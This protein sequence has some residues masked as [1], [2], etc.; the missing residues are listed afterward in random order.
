MSS[1]PSLAACLLCLLLLDA[2]AGGPEDWPCWRG[3]QATNVSLERGWSS[4]G[5][6]RPLWQARVGSGYSSPVVCAGR[7]VIAGYFEDESTPHAGSD[8]VSCLDAESGEELWSSTYPAQAFDNEH[9]GGALSSATIVG[10]VVFVPTRSGEVRAFSLA[11]GAL[12]WQVDLKQR[13]GVDPGRYGFASS[14][15][16]VGSTIVLNAERTLALERVSGE[17]SW[18]S[19]NYEARYSTPAAI[20]LGERECLVLFGSAGLVALDAN[21]GELVRKHVFTEK[22][23]NVEGATPI[24]VGQRVFI[25][26]AYDH[27]GQLVDFGPELPELV[28]GTKTMRSKMAGCTLWEGHLYGFDE[29]MLRCIALADGAE[30]WRQR[31]LGQ[32]ALS[33]ADGRLLTTSSK[34]ELIV[35]RATPQAFV[36]ESRRQ[37][38]EGG[39]FWTAPVLASGRIYFRGS[40][41]ELV[42]LDHRS[43]V[44]ARELAAQSAGTGS[45]AT[46]LPSPAALLERYLRVAGYDRQPMTG[47]RMQGRLH[48]EALGLEDSAASW[49]ITPEG[50][51]HVRYDLP[52]SMPGA[53][54]IY[55][56]GEHAWEV[57]PRRGGG[58]IEGSELDELRRTRG[59]RDLFE[60]VPAGLAAQTVGL[61]DFHGLECL[62]VDVQLT[63]DVTRSVFFDP[64]T[65][66]LAGRTSEQE[67]TV[68][69]GEW[70]E[71]GGVWLP[72]ERTDFRLDDGEESRWRFREASFET[73]PEESFAMP[74]DVRDQLP[75][76]EGFKPLFN[77]RDLAGWLPVNTAPS[78][79]QVID[80]MLHCSGKPTGELRTQR[81]YQNFVLEFEWR[82]L[83]PGGNAGLFVWADDLTARGVPFHRGIEVQVLDT[84]YGEGEGHTT[85]GDIFPIH[86]ARMTP[87]NG[88]GGSRAFPSELRSKPS[89]EWNHYR[90]TCQDG[91]ITLAVNGAL[92][93]R[94]REAWPSKGYLC[95]E[96]EGG[97]VDYRGL[98][99]RELPETPLDASRVARVDRGYDS[100]YSGLDLVGW[101]ASEAGLASWQPR[102]WI[103]ACTGAATGAEARLSSVESYSDFGF[104]LDL[105]I[106]EDVP[107]ARLLLRGE[108]PLSLDPRAHG[109]A[110][111]AGW[112][113]F[114]G[115]LIGDVLELRIDDQR[116]LEETLDELPEAGSLCIEP[117]GPCEF[118]NLFV[119]TDA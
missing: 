96:S 9:A 64:R 43:T 11:D 29:S 47:L 90:V 104:L 76:A 81:M 16:V 88:R 58:P 94:G 78:T 7:L 82:H 26:S 95:L 77:G 102:D 2:R 56:D 67:S 38:V 48:I 21:S 112:H 13:H 68:V 74:Q 22:A 30:C 28:W 71:F 63:P 46:E 23:R 98:R 119:T 65:G 60:P 113:R 40:L 15:L 36:E 83:V 34:G 18:I 20:T 42:C 85:H 66:L 109:Q 44:P 8:R 41:G 99:I 106:D 49:E 79:W 37:V 53:I 116:V 114:E 86:G 97:E 70:R 107:P 72:F 105:R 31:G 87:V 33:I 32:G 39:V 91:E 80:G 24:V 69:L 62:R 115:S 111:R 45:T 14:A 5:R 27:G 101:S 55:F 100:L 84:A 103:L 57:N 1:T 75:D 52:P 93:T 35:A 54:D 59:L 50:R 12:L 4:T 25:S 108:L 118:A 73:S 3:P 117:G 51:W 61:E 110:F 92:V 89:P 19:D 17:T 6:E 10:E